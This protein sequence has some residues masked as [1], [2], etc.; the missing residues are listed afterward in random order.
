MTEQNKQTLEL[1]NA[2]IKVGDYERFLYYCTEDTVWTFV[3]EQTLR[4]KEA[5][6]RYM[7]QTYLE[8]PDFEVQRMIAEGDMVM[9]LGKIR[10]KDTSG[11]MVSYDYCDVWQFTDG[12]LHEL[13][14]FVIE[15][16][17]QSAQHNDKPTVIGSGFSYDEA[18][19]PTDESEP[20]SQVDSEEIIGLPDLGKPNRP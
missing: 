9:A 16:E 13:K 19:H 12:R 20:A 18:V 7:A 3:G 4:G 8:P 14:A 15:G 5:V 2:A 6:R 10:F 17:T 11:T 1:A